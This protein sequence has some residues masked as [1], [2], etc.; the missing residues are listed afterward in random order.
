MGPTIYH[1]FSH[2]FSENETISKEHV[3]IDNNHYVYILISLNNNNNITE[4]HILILTSMKLQ[5]IKTRRNNPFAIFKE[6]GTFI[7][8]IRCKSSY[9]V[10]QI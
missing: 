5:M 9:N 7:Y 3:Y 10:L 1:L 8:S 4:N 2:T 6:S